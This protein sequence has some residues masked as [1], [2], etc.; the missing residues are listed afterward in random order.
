MNI[1]ETFIKEFS[2]YDKRPLFH[3]AQ[4]FP[5][6]NQFRLLKCKTQVLEARYYWTYGKYE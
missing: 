1:Y 5:S 4:Y 2:L 6:F 3:L